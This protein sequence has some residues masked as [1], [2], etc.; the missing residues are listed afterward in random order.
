MH[1]D[2][3]STHGLHFSTPD[4]PLTVLWNRADGYLL[5]AA[6]TRTEW[7]FPAPEM[8]EDGWATKTDVLLPADGG[9]TEV[10]SFGR[11]RQLAASNG[12]VQLT[13]DG[14]PRIYRGLLLDGIDAGPVVTSGAVSVQAKRADGRAA[15]VVT[16]QGAADRDMDVRIATT[17]GSERIERLAPGEIQTRTFVAEALTIPAGTATIRTHALGSGQPETHTIDYDAFDARPIG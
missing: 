12:E 3:G 11:S 6:G 4:G 16:V 1:L 14:A 7:R 2:D 17:F 9:V 5:N 8:W 10:D 13:L 15:L